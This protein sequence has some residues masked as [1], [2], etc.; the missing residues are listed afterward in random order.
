MISF[1]DIYE[2]NNQQDIHLV[3]NHQDL[4]FKLIESSLNM[5]R[6]NLSTENQIFKL[7]ELIKLG[8]LKNKKKKQVD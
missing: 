6:L 3:I 5:S 8:N 1:D 4:I 2:L 7:K